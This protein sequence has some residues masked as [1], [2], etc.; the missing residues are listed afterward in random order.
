MPKRDDEIG[1][2]SLEVIDSSF[3][4]MIKPSLEVYEE[5]LVEE[6]GKDVQFN[7]VVLD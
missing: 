5:F 2:K 7:T 3:F 1:I 4:E 6:Y